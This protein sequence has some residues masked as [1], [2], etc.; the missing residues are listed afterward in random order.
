[1]SESRFSDSYDL[2]PIDSSIMRNAI[3]VG[4]PG[5]L[6]FIW[7]LFRATCFSWRSARRVSGDER[8]SMVARIVAAVLSA[9]VLNSVF[10]MTFTLYSVAPIAWLLIGW[11]S[12][13]TARERVDREIV[14]I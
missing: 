5:V 9:I 7:I 11:V 13:E 12:A 2:P 3:A 8:R 10:G 1:L 4:I 14:T 6:L